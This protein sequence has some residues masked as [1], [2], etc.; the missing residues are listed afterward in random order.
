MTSAHQVACITLAVLLS[1]TLA[2][3][4]YEGMQPLAGNTFSLSGVSPQNRVAQE[5][6]AR[7]VPVAFGVML[8]VTVAGGLWLARTR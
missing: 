3:C 7:A 8:P 2:Y 6:L 1:A 4:H 5:H